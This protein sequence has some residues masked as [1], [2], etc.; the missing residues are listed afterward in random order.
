MPTGLAK[1]LC[2]CI[3]MLLINACAT[4]P[5]VTTTAISGE[6][7]LDIKLTNFRNNNGQAIIFIYS[8]PE[9]FPDSDAP[10]LKRISLPIKENQV[11]FI[12]D[13]LTYRP[14]AI[15]VLHDE[16]LNDQM[17]KT[18]FGFPREGFGFSRNPESLFGP[19]DYAEAQFLFFSKQQQQKIQMQYP[20]R[21]KHRPENANSSA[22]RLK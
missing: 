13:E 2:V 11:H 16:N 12:L 8:G 6:G 10:N 18:L 19:P 3:L 5:S 4:M 21:R 7:Q 15:A 9:G 1:S 17:D 14:Y 22:S 20:K